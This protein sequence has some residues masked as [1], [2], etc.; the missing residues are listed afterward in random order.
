MSPKILYFLF[1]MGHFGPEWTIPS[2]MDKNPIAW[3]IQ[4]DG[5]IMDARSAPL[6]IQEEAFRLGIIPYIPSLKKEK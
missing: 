1:D 5:F 4:V 3:L 6:S 2:M